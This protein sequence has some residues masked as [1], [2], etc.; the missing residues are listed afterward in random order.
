M[1]DGRPTHKAVA[2]P[3][4][5]PRPWWGSWGPVFPEQGPATLYMGLVYMDG[6]NK[7]KLPN[8]ALMKWYYQYVFPIHF[9]TVDPDLSNPENFDV[10]VDD[11]REAWPRY[12]KVHVV[13]KTGVPN[14]VAPKN[15]QYLLYVEYGTNRITVTK[16]HFVRDYNVDLYGQQSTSEVGTT[17]LR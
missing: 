7:R 9:A 16:S 6:L 11:I 3:F 5:A 2:P 15:V 12:L 10:A 4:A 14:R 8:D 1:Q 17:E 13:N